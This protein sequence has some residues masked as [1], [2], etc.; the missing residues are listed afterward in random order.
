MLSYVRLLLVIVE[1]DNKW[2]TIVF[3]VLN[4][5]TL[6]SVNDIL[7]HLKGAAHKCKLNLAKLTLLK[8]NNRW[9]FSD[10]ILLFDASIKEDMPNSEELRILLILLQEFHVFH[11]SCLIHYWI[12]WNEYEHCRN[13]SPN[14]NIDDVEIYG[15]FCPACNMKNNLQKYYDD[16]QVCFLSS[17]ISSEFL[18]TDYLHYSFNN[19]VFFVVKVVVQ[20]SMLNNSLA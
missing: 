7:D 15:L 8:R 13:Y 3:C 20:N 9:P 4:H 19:G 14:T 5:A 11:T 12:L 1:G 6:R 16:S 10:G 2:C 17:I 18:F